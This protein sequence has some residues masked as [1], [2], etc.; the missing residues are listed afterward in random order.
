MPKHKLF[1]FAAPSLGVALFVASL[2]VTPVP[3]LGALAAQSTLSGE[4]GLKS[5]TGNPGV[6][7]ER[8]DRSH[9]RVSAYLRSMKGDSDKRLTELADMVMMRAA[10]FAL[11]NGREYFTIIGDLDT[12][13]TGG[14]MEHYRGTPDTLGPEQCGPG[15][16]G[17]GLVCIPRETIKGTPSSSSYN[18]GY[19]GRVGI[20]QFWTGAEGRQLIEKREGQP[21]KGQ[22]IPA[23]GFYKMFRDKTP[24]KW[25]E[26][27]EI[28]GERSKRM[29][30]G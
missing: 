1:K 28:Y 5:R 25:P 14:K 22:P 2:T 17:I 11:E 16:A 21:V 7:V 12:D 18:P 27:S 4:H 10:Q 3:L 24:G 15:P 29:R 13:T 8:I 9:Y 30:G 26:L 23:E 20:I 6:Y 19:F